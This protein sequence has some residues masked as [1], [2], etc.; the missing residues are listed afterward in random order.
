MNAGPRCV[1]KRAGGFSETGWQYDQAAVVATLE[2]LPTEPT[3]ETAWQRFLPTGPV[4]LLP[5]SSTVSSLVWSTSRD[6]A[7]RLV[8]LD[9]DEF[10][11][12]LNHVVNAPIE[13]FIDRKIV[14]GELLRALNTGI[15]AAARK[16][17]S[18]LSAALDA[19]SL[20]KHAPLVQRVVEGSRASFPLSLA[21]ADQ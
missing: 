18:V 20:P 13:D 8:A 14:D 2:V 15:N 12:E 5:L 21:H 11:A 4:A 10:A 16:A 3:N 17:E 1:V 19:S 6:E 7:Q 9:D